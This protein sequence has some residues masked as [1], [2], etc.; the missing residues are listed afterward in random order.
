M[1][2]LHGTIAVAAGA[3]GHLVAASLGHESFAIS[4]RSYVKRE[5]NRRPPECDFDRRPRVSKA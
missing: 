2:G 4:E 3:T 5:A 1:R